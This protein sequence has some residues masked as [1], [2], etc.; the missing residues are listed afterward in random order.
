MKNFIKVIDHM[1]A[2]RFINVNHI[3]S[4]TPLYSDP[5]SKK[6]VVI[7]LNTIFDTS[8]RYQLIT[9]PGEEISDILRSIEDALL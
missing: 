1:G 3:S 4:I 7:A 5:R 8:N 2:T 6:G 9:V